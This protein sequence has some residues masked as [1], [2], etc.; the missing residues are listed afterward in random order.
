[1]NVLSQICLNLAVLLI[2]RNELYP[3]VKSRSVDAM[4]VP[5]HCLSRNITILIVSFVSSD[6]ARS[7][8][9]TP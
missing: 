7:T 9:P 5:L 1:M 3:S 6:A 4:A 8:S 2:F